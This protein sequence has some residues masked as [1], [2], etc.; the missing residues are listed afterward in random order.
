MGRITKETW[1]SMRSEYEDGVYDLSELSEEYGIK[2]ETVKNRADAEKW[3][4]PETDKT[5]RR[6]K[7]HRVKMLDAICNSTMAGLEKADVLLNECEN[8]RDVELHSK[9][10]KNYKDIC[11]GKSPDEFL[12]DESADGNIADLMSELDNL[13]VEDAKAI[14]HEAK[15]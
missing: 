9:T 1:T 5:I 3:K 10:V 8:L 4:R 11:I 2:T 12:K 6:L 15:Q 14:M 7:N 13:S